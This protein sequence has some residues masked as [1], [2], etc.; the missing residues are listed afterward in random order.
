L[1]KEEMVAPDAIDR[2]CAD[3][4]TRRD[5]GDH[6]LCRVITQQIGEWKIRSGALLKKVQRLLN[7]TRHWKA[8]VLFCLYRIQDQRFPVIEHFDRTVVARHADG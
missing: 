3:F 8:Y 4:T 1:F 5:A 2:R 6:C 7:T